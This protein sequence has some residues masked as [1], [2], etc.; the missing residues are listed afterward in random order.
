MQ[1]PAVYQQRVEH[2]EMIASDSHSEIHL[3][4]HREITTD[5]W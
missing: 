3:Q 5:V 4:S 1:W 2:N